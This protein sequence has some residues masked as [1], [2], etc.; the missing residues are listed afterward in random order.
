MY[1]IKE[2]NLNHV[3]GGFDVADIGY[4]VG[5]GI[6]SAISSINSASYALGVNIYEW[7]H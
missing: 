3:S 5:Y 4:A 6:G 1:V 2:D 7:T